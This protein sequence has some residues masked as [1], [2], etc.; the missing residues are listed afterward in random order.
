MAKRLNCT[1]LA[2]HPSFRISSEAIFTATFIC[3]R[4]PC[5]ARGDATA[6]LRNSVGTQT[7]SSF[8]LLVVPRERRQG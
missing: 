3:N 6:A 7:H 2:S 4:L 8:W 5:S 1:R